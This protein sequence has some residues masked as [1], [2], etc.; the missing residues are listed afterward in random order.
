VILYFYVFFGIFLILDYVF[1]DFLVLSYIF[2]GG[3]TPHPPTPTLH[4]IVGVKM[5]GGFVIFSAPHHSMTQLAAV[6]YCGN[7]GSRQIVV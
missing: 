6:P 3:T 1:S 7:G 5:G 2:P 4:W